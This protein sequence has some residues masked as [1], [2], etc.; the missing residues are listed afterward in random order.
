MK[1]IL[2]IGMGLVAMVLFLGTTGMAQAQTELKKLGQNPFYKPALQT[3]DDFQEMIK[4]TLP[5]LKKGFTMAGAEALFD[6]FLIQVDQADI[7]TVDVPTGEKLQWM[8]Y[9]KDQRVK[10][11]KNVVWAGKESFRA[12]QLNVDQNGHRNV[13]VVPLICG[14]VALARTTAAPAPSVSSAPEAMDKP[15]PVIPP[16]AAAPAPAPVSTTATDS[17]WT[18]PVLK[19]GQFVAD[20]GFLHQP[21]PA[22]YLLFRAGYDYR[23]HENYSVLGMVG[24]APVTSGDDDTDSVMA[25]L[26]SY[27]HLDRMHLGGGLGLWHSSTKDRVDL[28]LNAGYR[29]YGEAYQRNVSLFVETRAAFDQFDDLKKYIRYG[30]GI[31]V[32]F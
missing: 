2:K 8:I 26:T 5:D 22:N 19:R 7:E 12:F 28:I 21:D 29:I 25:D 13:F 31:R 11:M 6:D 15:K 17:S 16:A 27:Y 23:F 18:E 30:G 24:F 9:Q 3:V 10:V 4:K 32:H 14:N 1:K 20:L